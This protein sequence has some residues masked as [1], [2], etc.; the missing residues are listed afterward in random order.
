MAGAGGNIL[1]GSVISRAGRAGHSEILAA[2]VKPTSGALVFGI[3]ATALRREA[4]GPLAWWEWVVGPLIPLVT[5]AL[6]VVLLVVVGMIVGRLRKRLG[7]RLR[8]A[9][10]RLRRQPRR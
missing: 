6:G 9:L 8:I 3:V 5:L 4:R 1:A 10:F 2:L 7:R